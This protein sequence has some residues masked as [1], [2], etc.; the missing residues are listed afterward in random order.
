ML[1]NLKRMHEE[2]ITIA[3]ST[4]A[5][6]PGTLHGI[7]IY[8]EMEAMQAAGIRAKDIIL[9]ATKNGAMA[10]DRLNDFVTLENGK[11]ADLIILAS[12]PSTDISNMRSITSLQNHFLFL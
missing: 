6:N 2:G 1:D 8:D 4:D 10:M 3:V 11:M 5:G 12:D 9:M 7:S